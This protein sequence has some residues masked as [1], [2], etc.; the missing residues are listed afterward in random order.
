MFELDDVEHI[1]LTRTPAITERYEFLAF[2]TPVGGRAWLSELL[3]TPQSAADA[4]AILDGSDRWVTLAFY[5]DRFA[6]VG[7]AGGIVWPPFPTSSAKACS[8]GPASWATP[9]TMPPNIGRRPGR[10]RSARDRDLVLA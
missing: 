2:D 5:V 8:S 6:G 4:V 9:A 1:L 10:R 3:D 7:R